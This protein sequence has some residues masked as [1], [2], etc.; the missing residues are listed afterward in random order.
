[1]AREFSLQIGRRVGDLCADQENVVSRAQL[2]AAGVTRTQI[3]TRLEAKLWQPAYRGTYIT[4]TGVAAYRER[5]WSAVL[6][7]GAGAMASHETA[8]YLGRLLDGQPR[9]VHI[10]VPGTRRVAPQAG[11]KLHLAG[12]AQSRLQFGSAPPRTTIEEAVLDIAGAKRSPD[13]V[14]A[15]LTG[16]CQRR[17]T[18][19]SRLRAVAGRRRKLAWRGLLNEILRDVECG[20]ESPLESRYLRGV[21]RPHGLPRGLRQA[22][23]MTAGRREY[24]DVLYEEYGVIVELDG[25]TSHADEQVFRDMQRD[26]AAAAR[27]EVSLRYGWRDVVGA[28]CS[29]AQQVATVLRQRGWTGTLRRCSRCRRP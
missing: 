17:L 27:A 10:L 13:D 2:L 25:L 20:V 8:A 18:S 11:L 12:D 22:G 6:Y 19:P 28:P 21:E 4:H 3:R 14:V 26:N 5:V 29:V 7:A 15:V 16:A 23:V 1:M 9:E 24:R